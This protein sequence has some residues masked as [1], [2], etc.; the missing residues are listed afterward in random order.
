M[1]EEYIW[2]KCNYKLMLG[3]WKIGIMLEAGYQVLQSA[4]EREGCTKL[5]DRIYFQSMLLPYPSSQPLTAEELD[6]FCRGLKRVSDQIENAFP[7][8]SCLKI[9]LRSIQFSD[10]DIQNEAFTASAIQW[11]SET[12]QFPMPDIRVHFDDSKGRNGM[13][14]FDFYGVEKS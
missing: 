2:K 4:E 3:K 11:A 7:E 12:F 9:A 1:I 14:R 6:D 10:C 8:D 5:T 13:Y